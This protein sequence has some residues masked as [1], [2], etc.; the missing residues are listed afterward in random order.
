MKRII[1]FLLVAVVAVSMLAQEKKG[2]SKN[3]FRQM[4]TEFNTP[5]AYRTGSGAPGQLYWQQQANYKISIELDDEKQ[6][7]RGE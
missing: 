3:Q 7:I 6:L 2:P 5:N 1:S 4:R